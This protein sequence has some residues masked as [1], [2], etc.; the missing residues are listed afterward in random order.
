[1]PY[2]VRGK[3]VYKKGTNKKVGCT[4]GDVKKYAAALYSAEKKMEEE[5]VKEEIKNLFLEDAEAVDKKDAPTAGSKEFKKRTAVFRQ[6]DPLAIN[7]EDEPHVAPKG[8]EKREKSNIVK[9]VL[10]SIGGSAAGH[11]FKGVPRSDYSLT[12]SGNFGEQKTN[13]LQQIMKE[14][15]EIMLAEA[16]KKNINEQSGRQYNLSQILDYE[17]SDVEGIHP[18]DHCASVYSCIKSLKKRYGFDS[19]S[20][21]RS[22]LNNEL[23]KRYPGCAQYIPRITKGKLGSKFAHGVRP[24]AI[25]SLPRIRNKFWR[26]NVGNPNNRKNIIKAIGKGKKLT[27]DQASDTMRQIWKFLNATKMKF[28]DFKDHPG[29]CAHQ[30]HP[31]FQN[32][33]YDAKNN[34]I[35]ICSFEG[36]WL[37]AFKEYQKSPST[38]NVWFQVVSHE[39]AH[40]KDTIIARLAMAGGQS[41]GKYTGKGKASLSSAAYSVSQFKHI[42]RCFPSIALSSKTH[43]KRVWEHYGFVQDLKSHLGRTKFIREDFQL[44]CELKRTGKARAYDYTNKAMEAW[45]EKTPALSALYERWYQADTGD[46]NAPTAIAIKRWLKTFYS[47]RLWKFLD[48]KKC[49]ARA[50]ERSLNRLAH[51]NTRRPTPTRRRTAPRPPTLAQRSA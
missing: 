34:T 2:D 43:G 17:C 15:I 38:S 47:A 6:K 48:C 11:G 32:A 46:A 4:K 41:K 26:I 12:Y 22:S 29:R 7:L 50:L 14:E 44:A 1:M 27:P 36:Q 10:K 5:I 25:R 21:S 13:K 19:L 30:Q 42:K 28:V 31:Q 18:N 9:R 16:A 23:K 20:L 49:S 39:L 35:K 40:A 45:I 33:F 24:A 51:V 3:C 37:K 8:A